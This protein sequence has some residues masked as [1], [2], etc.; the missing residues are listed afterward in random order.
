MFEPIKVKA[1]V[2]STE[3]KKEVFIVAMENNND[4]RAVVGNKLCTAVYNTY[5]EL[6]YVDDKYGVIDTIEESY[7]G[8]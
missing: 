1:M 2:H 3:S 6:F 8:T 7:N 4:C 5:N